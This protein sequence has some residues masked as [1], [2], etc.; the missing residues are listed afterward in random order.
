M[1][2]LTNGNWANGCTHTIIDDQPYKPDCK[3]IM[4]FFLQLDEDALVEALLLE[5]ESGTLT[6]DEADRIMFGYCKQTFNAYK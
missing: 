3:S 5:T 2:I 4:Q 1:T 6:Q